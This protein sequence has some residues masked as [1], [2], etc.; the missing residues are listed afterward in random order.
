MSRRHFSIT[1]PNFRMI[2]PTLSHLQGKQPPPSLPLP[3]PPSPPPFSISVKD[4]FILQPLKLRPLV[5]VPSLSSHT[6]KMS[7]KPNYALTLAL[8]HPECT[9]RT[10]PQTS[11]LESSQD[12]LLSNHPQYSNTDK[13][14]SLPSLKIK[15]RWKQRKCPLKGKWT[16]K[17]WSS[18]TTE[19]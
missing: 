13:I 16:N 6:A 14:T 11:I 10:V 3:P 7:P 2:F 12:S 8:D 19:F 5:P 17:M 1:S 4:I 18:H 9:S 15:I